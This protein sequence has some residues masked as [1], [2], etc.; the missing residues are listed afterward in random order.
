M[1]TLGYNNHKE[2]KKDLA[3]GKIRK[4]FFDADDKFKEMYLWSYGYY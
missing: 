1:K 3:N 4:K 2:L